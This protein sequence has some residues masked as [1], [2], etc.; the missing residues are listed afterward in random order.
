M[1]E[2]F[3]VGN[4]VS[5]VLKMSP[6]GNLRFVCRIFEELELLYSKTA[7]KGNM[8]CSNMKKMKHSTNNKDPYGPEYAIRVYDPKIGMEGFLVIDNTALGSGKGGIRMTANVTQEEVLR[9]ARTMTWKN[10]LAGIPFGGAKAGIVW[11]PSDE[12]K[13]DK[14]KL[15]ETKKLF[16]QSFARA[17]SGF[18]PHTYIAGPDVNT[19]E[20]EMA[21]FVAA[22][23]N[24]KSATGK[25]KKLGGL[26]HELGSTG[27]G[28]FHATKTAAEISGLNLK[29]TTIAIEGFGNVGTF[30]AKYL[31]GAGA[32]IIA[33]SD[34]G[35]TAFNP[36]GLDYKTMMKVKAQ[37]GTVTAYP[38]A[39]KLPYDS[40][41]GLD[42]DILITA[43]VTDVINNKN[44]HSIRAKI[45][46][47]GSNIPMKEE[48]EKELWKRG[49]MIVPDFV[50]NAGGVISS[51]A[52]YRGFSP[53]NMFALVEEKVGK[54][55]KKILTI[56]MKRNKNPRDVAL[57]LAQEKVVRAMKKRKY[58]F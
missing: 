10:A 3:L 43:A 44:K 41:F 20:T 34:R 30:A 36:R 58:V 9:L 42:V 54:T 21:W 47:E 5:D 40:I 35:G 14:K 22:T 7:E 45:I 27:F 51:Y 17:I 31:E 28:V 52:E 1:V 48:I 8:K 11:N 23:G 16:V 6:W 18:T 55:T 38:G 39:H 24:K 19:G 46:V 49:I 4:Q 37:R 50:A 56:S 32:R 53:A 26:P 15:A 29:K 25:P 12:I 57:A 13:N 33:V 2:H